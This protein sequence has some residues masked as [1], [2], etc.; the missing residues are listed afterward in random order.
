MQLRLLVGYLGEK[1]QFGWWD[2]GF[3]DATGRRFLESTFPRTAFAAA[4]RS[5]AEA[6]CSVHDSRIGRVGVFH[7]FR[8]PVEREP[9][10]DRELSTNLPASWVDLVANREAALTELNRLAGSQITAPPGPVQVG[11]VKRIISPAAVSELA[12]HYHSAFTRGSQT[13]P[14]FAG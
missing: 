8:L 13:F 14:Y 11:L 10:L 2:T 1:K 4:I 3:L 6:A 12:A 9:A 5:T 7:L